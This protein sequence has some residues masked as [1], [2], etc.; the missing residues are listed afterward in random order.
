[1]N[2][3]YISDLSR[4]KTPYFDKF[5]ATS[6]DDST[7]KR[8]L[9]LQIIGYLCTPLMKAK[10][11]F[12][13][14][15][16]PNSGKSL[17]I[18]I[19]EYMFGKSLISNIQLENLGNRFSSGILSTKRLN[20]C[21]E[22][23]AH[24]LKNIELFKLI[25]G[26]DTLSGEFKGRDVFQFEN[27]C[28][29]LYAGNVLPPVKNEDISTAFVD[30]LT[31]LKFSHSIPREE[32]IYNLDEKLKDEADAIFTLAINSVAKLIEN[33]FEFVVPQD[34]ADLL[35]DY[36]FQQTNIDTFVEEWC[37]L[38]EELKTHSAT[39]Y[40]FYKRF[41]VDNA[42]QPI[43]QNLFSQKIGSVKGVTNGRFRLNGGNPMRGFCG[44]AVKDIYL[45]DS[46]K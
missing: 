39:L 29:L 7:D 5:C 3:K 24:P 42:I 18:L 45:Q 20:V 8:Q 32:R 10:K 9:L 40:T 15:G 2:V 34:S 6:L 31:V 16:E 44:I 43:S 23:S 35:K 14:L 13:F 26:G 4:V 27:R 46:D 38:G 33:Q 12:I 28:K 11:C 19:I 37:E 25:V 41:C 22:L 17:M 30:R 36:S 21:A 1:M